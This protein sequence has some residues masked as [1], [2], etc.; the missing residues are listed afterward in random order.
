[1]IKG[2]LFDFD[3]VMVD[4]ISAH[5]KAWN[6]AFIELFKNAIIPEDL[7]HMMGRSTAYISN[8]L[9]KK[10][11]CEW[12]ANE[13]ASRKNELALASAKEVKLL[14]GT[15][16][17]VNELH[18]RKIPFGIVSN[19]PRS[20]IGEVLCQHHLKV[21]FFTGVE[22][23]KRPKPAPD[24]YIEGAFKLK[25]DFPNF[26]YVLTFEDSTHGLSAAK[27]AFTVPIG[28]CTQHQDD[29][30]I[31]AGAIRTYRDLA[32]ALDDKIL[33]WDLS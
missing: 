20:F 19:A 11:N 10:Q 16:D 31:Q 12:R 21:P 26:K 8:Y 23:H 6:L 1:M 30:L 25:L 13:L 18:Q 9:C 3:G 4:S 28:I 5:L 14:P 32:H 27:K 2:V 22:D 24:P 29:I 15:D 33:D 7:N 17:I